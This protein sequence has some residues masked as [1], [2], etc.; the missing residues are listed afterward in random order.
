MGRRGHCALTAQVRVSNLQF[1]PRRLRN[2]RRT[3]VIKYGCPYIRR[4]KK[5]VPSASA[6]I[7]CADASAKT[8][9]PS[10]RRCWGRASQGTFARRHTICPRILHISG[11]R[12]RQEKP[13]GGGEKAGKWGGLHGRR[14]VRQQ[15]GRGGGGYDLPSAGDDNGASFTGDNES[16]I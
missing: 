9:A 13:R 15:G 14:G 16:S 4:E 2:V 5:K 1:D 7:S 11:C 12:K 8:A 10:F 6:Q 3:V